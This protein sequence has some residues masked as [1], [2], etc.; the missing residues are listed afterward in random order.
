VVRKVGDTPA[1][2]SA[3]VEDPFV[4]S[5]T[6]W[7]GRRDGLWLRRLCSS[8][9]TVVCRASIRRAYLSVCGIQLG[10]AS[11]GPVCGVRVIDRGEGAECCLNDDVAGIGADFE[12]FIGVA[13]RVS[14]IPFSVHARPSF[15]WQTVTRGQAGVRSQRRPCTVLFASG[16]GGEVRR[17]I[18][19]LKA[20]A[21][22]ERLLATT[23]NCPRGA[24]RVSGVGTQSPVR[25]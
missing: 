1:R 3:E 22:A 24:V 14:A 6:L 10:H 15:R 17:T 21:G 4:G 9:D 13:V 23:P 19:R 12:H 5:H 16:G 11:G 8:T 25:R 18:A 7:S 2:V 20:P